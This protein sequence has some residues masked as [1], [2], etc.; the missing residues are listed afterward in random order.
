MSKQ[1]ER[2]A[3][4]VA[5]ADGDSLAGRALQDQAEEDG[6]PEMPQ[7]ARGDWVVIFTA[8]FF[9]VGQLL[10]VDHEQYCLAAGSAQVFET[11]PF[12]VFFGKGLAAVCET[13]SEVTWVRKGPTTHVSRWPF[14]RPCKVS[15]GSA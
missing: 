11:G 13:I 8:A 12:D 10:G 3:L 7:L 14:T 6:L 9:H 15:Q 1:R 5:E 4:L 2:E